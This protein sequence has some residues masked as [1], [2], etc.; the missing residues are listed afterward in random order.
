MADSARWGRFRLRDDDIVISTP[1]KC[2]TTWMQNI[3][4]MLVL[5]RPV[6]GV[7]LST[8]SPWLDMLTHTD[9]QVFGLLDAQQHRRWIKTHTPLDGLPLH[10]TVTYIAVVRHP[11]DVALSDRDHRANEDQRRAYELR[12]SASGTPDDGLRRN[13]T[14][15]APGDCLRWFIDN[16]APPTGSGPNGLDDFCQ[17]VSTYWSQRNAPN[18]H[19]F[20]YQDLWDDLDGEMRRVADA[21]GVRVDPSRWAEFVDAANLESMRSRASETA[22]EAH[23]A[24]WLDPNNFFRVGGRRDWASL[25]TDSDIAHFRER[26]ALLAGDATPW[27]LG[28]RAGPT[29]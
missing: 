9:E 12:V 7:P 20:H 19:L 1:S 26:L 3:V 15:Q 21:L 10:P 29:H 28:G 11:L 13:P 23:L 8:V 5:D 18:V 27:V 24:F 14:H 6:L 2:G 16:D 25:L 4:G 17:Q 22:P